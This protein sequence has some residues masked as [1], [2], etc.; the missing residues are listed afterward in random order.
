MNE[1]TS[2]PRLHAI[3]RWLLGDVYTFRH[4][5]TGATH[6]IRARSKEAARQKMFGFV[7]EA[8]YGGWALAYDHAAVMRE[9]E[10]CE[11]I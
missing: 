1:P 10:K 2:T 6:A 3:V 11:I 9:L 8:M 5:E 7:L 4:K